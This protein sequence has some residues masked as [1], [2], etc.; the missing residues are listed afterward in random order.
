MHINLIRPCVGVDS[1]ET[2]HEIQQTSRLLY[3]EDG[4]PYTYFTTRNSPKRR[5]ELINGG[6]IYWIT[7]GAIRMRQRI[8]D[9]ET[10]EDENNKKYCLISLDPEIMLTVPEARRAMQGWRYLPPEQSPADLHPLGEDSNE[11][12]PSPDMAQK[13]AEA[14]LL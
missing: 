10:L 5:D 1:P 12:A 3:K 4:T 9:I 6:S 13:L 14:G 7:K 8:I 2:L 11:T